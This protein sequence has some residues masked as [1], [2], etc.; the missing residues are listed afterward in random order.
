[1]K[2]NLT[3]LLSTKTKGVLGAHYHIPGTFSTSEIQEKVSWLLQD[4]VFKFGGIDIVVLEYSVHIFILIIYVIFFLQ[5]QTYSKQD[6]YNH[7]IVVNVVRNIWFSAKGKCDAWAAKDMLDK[8]IV[9][10]ETIALI[11]TRMSLIF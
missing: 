4:G 7:P 6:P 2:D 10:G 8:G 5:T 9:A 11:F 1:M 3:T